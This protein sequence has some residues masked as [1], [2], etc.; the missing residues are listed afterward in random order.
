MHYLRALTPFFALGMKALLR[1][2]PNAI[3][4]TQ[5]EVAD[6]SVGDPQTA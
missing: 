4:V 3:V 1:L 2:L 6:T 5:P